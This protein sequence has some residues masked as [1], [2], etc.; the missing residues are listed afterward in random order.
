M[1]MNGYPF[2]NGV[3]NHIKLEKTVPYKPKKSPFDLLEKGK[4]YEI[5][6]D[7]D[8]TDIYQVRGFFMEVDDYQPRVILCPEGDS[9]GYSYNDYEILSVK[10][11]TKTNKNIF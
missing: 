4:W 10:E 2:V 7:G 1:N 8:G 11:I 9:I 6:I 5:V 3:Y